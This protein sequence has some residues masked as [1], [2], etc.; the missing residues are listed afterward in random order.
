VISRN[1]QGDLDAELTLTRLAVEPPKAV[2]RVLEMVHPDQFT[3]NVCA[4]IWHVVQKLSRSG[5]PVGFDQVVNELNPADILGPNGCSGATTVADC[6]R[7]T[8]SEGDGTADE[9]K[10]CALRI[11]AE[12]HR[13]ALRDVIDCCKQAL[14]GGQSKEA[15]SLL[16]KASRL[17]EAYRKPTSRPCAS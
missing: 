17:V 5:R 12:A 11:R 14:V 4:R 2:A 8:V 3:D 1:R 6:V 7:Q 10:W 15:K 13:Q 9:A 16:E